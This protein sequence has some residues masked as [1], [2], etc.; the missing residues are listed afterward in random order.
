MSQLRPK[1]EE[2]LRAVEREKGP[3]ALFAALQRANGLGLW[4]VIV[5]APW[6]SYEEPGSVSFFFSQLMEHTTVADRLMI[7]RA[8]ILDTSEP[9]VQ[10]V[11]ELARRVSSE[12]PIELGHT[13]MG[14]L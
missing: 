2:T 11:V 1:V 14:G 10:E 6:L 9:F 8:V 7:S 13:T 12:V 3:F 4:D 5:S